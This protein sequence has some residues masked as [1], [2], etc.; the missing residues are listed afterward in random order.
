MNGSSSTIRRLG[1]ALTLAVALAM[2]SVGIANA[3]TT[4]TTTAATTTTNPSGM[5]KPGGMN[6]GGFAVHAPTIARALGIT[7]TELQTEMSA[8]KTVAQIATAKG[9][10]LQKVIDAY[11]TEET[12][13]HPELANATVVQRVTDRLNG[14]RPTRPAGTNGSRPAKSGT[15][16]SSTTGPSTTAATVST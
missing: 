2:G 3:Q 15:I 8:G 16:P 14:V 13:E 12:V 7:T 11:V 5:G 10:S 4:N 6:G 1:G 9:V